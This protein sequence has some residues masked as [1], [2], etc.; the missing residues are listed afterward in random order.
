[1]NKKYRDMATPDF[2]G[3]AE[4]ANTI[5]EAIKLIESGVNI[6]SRTVEVLGEAEKKRIRR[7]VATAY[8]DIYTD[9]KL[10]IFKKYPE[11][12]NREDE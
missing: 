4:D 8:A 10:S 3:D 5:L 6:I 12:E 2:G 1:M 7:I 9:I 11:L